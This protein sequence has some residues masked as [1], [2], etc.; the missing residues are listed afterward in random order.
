MKQILYFLTLI[1]LGFGRLIPPAPYI[2]YAPLPFRY[3]NVV[4]PYPYTWRFGNEETCTRQCVDTPSCVGFSMRH[5]ECRFSNHTD[6]FVDDD[7]R[8]TSYSDSYTFYS[9]EEHPELEE[10]MKKWFEERNRKNRQANLDTP[11]LHPRK[12]VK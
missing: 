6:Q 9:K 10:L 7:S 4:D 5:S 1:G 2:N 3:S 8:T 12:N 11:R